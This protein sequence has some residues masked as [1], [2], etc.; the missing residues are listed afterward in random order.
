MKTNIMGLKK[1]IDIAILGPLMFLILLI[2][3]YAIFANN[4]FTIT[5]MVNIIRQISITGTMAVGVTMVILLGEID[6][7][8]AIVMAF[9]GMMYGGLS[10]GMYLGLPELPVGVCMIVVVL[11][12]AIIGLI[13]GFANSKLGIPGFM[14]TLAMQYACE[15]VMLTLTDAAPISG[16]REQV[17]FWGSGYLFGTIPMII[18]VFVVIFI[19][20]VILLKCTVFGRNLY[21]IGGNAEAAR[22]SGINVP[23]FKM[24]AFMLCSIL[25]SIAGILM[26]GRIGSA[27]VTA[28]DNLDMQPIAG[29]V[30]GGASLMGGKGSMFGTLLGVLTMGVLVNGLNILGASTAI[31]KIVTGV[32]LF[33]A[34]AFNIWTS[35]K[36]RK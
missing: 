10:K 9:S 27:Q 19:I 28:G 20:G 3:V 22:I 35:K 21:A 26:V 25:V 34:V 11:L 4:F 33:A 17:T 5:N 2:I 32:V 31:Q 15:G 1:K 24:L 7:S 36:S 8:M 18:I 16:L 29:T 23:K 30:L 14:A 13:S 6:L 12:G